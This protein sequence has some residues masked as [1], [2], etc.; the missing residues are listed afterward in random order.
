MAAR[1]DGD[2]AL[3]GFGKQRVV[4]RGE[5]DQQRA[6]AQVQLQVG[7]D[8][9][10]VGAHAAGVQVVDG[11]AAQA[12]MVHAV[13]RADELVGAVAEGDQAEAIGLGLRHQRQMQRRAHE[14]F[15]NLRA[16]GETGGVDDGVD[17]LRMLHAV[18]FHHR[19]LAAGSGF[20]ID[21]FESVAG[22][23]LAEI[24][25]FAALAHLAAHAQSDGRGA[26]EEGGGGAIAQVG[27]NADS[28]GHGTIRACQPEAERR[29]RFHVDRG[30]GM[31]A[32]FHAGACPVDAR[33]SWRNRG[34]LHD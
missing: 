14:A 23:I 27:I 20:P 3:E 26:L 31:I 32:A 34:V 30:D 4:E 33:G 28:P 1:Q 7:E 24:V 9:A 18:Q 8:I 13:A 15:Q 22:D 11:F 16:G 2:F 6:A 17:L 25:E 12:E 29:W 10:E 21:I 19:E 5:E